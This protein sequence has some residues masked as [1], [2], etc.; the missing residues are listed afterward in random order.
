MAK[1]SLRECPR[2]SLAKM[3]PGWGPQGE[4]G[5][6]GSIAKILG[7]KTWL[8]GGR[9]MFFF[10]PYLDT[11]V[12]FHIREKPEEFV[13]ISSFSAGSGFQG[14]GFFEVSCWCQARHPDLCD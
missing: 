14:R 9:T 1:T 7:C 12:C 11:Y 3:K 13:V 10:G 2:A 6:T 4:P 8:F 5:Q